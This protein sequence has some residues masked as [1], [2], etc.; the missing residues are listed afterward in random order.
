MVDE[1]KGGCFQKFK[2]WFKNVKCKITCSNCIV[3]KTENNIDIDVNGDG[4]VDYVIPL[5]A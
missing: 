1:V 2:V 3:N 5:S 4:V